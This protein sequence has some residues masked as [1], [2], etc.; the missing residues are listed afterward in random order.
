M[1]KYHNAQHRGEPVTYNRVCY[2]CKKEIH[3]PIEL[4]PR[5]VEKGHAELMSMGWQDVNHYAFCPTCIATP[6]TRHDYLTAKKFLFDASIVKQFE[7]VTVSRDTIYRKPDGSLWHESES[8]L[9]S[10]EDD[11]SLIWMSQPEEPE[12][13]DG[14]AGRDEGALWNGEVS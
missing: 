1:D 14:D 13:P 12:F 2:R 4:W 5:D 10:P 7:H 6:F 9:E 8:L 11:Y 3:I